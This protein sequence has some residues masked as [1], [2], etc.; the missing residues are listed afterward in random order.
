[1]LRTVSL[2]D[3]LPKF[4]QESREFQELLAAENPDVQALEDETEILKDNQF[5]L[6]CNEDGIKNFERLLG[7]T[8]A[9]DESLAFRIARVLARWNDTTPYT[10]RVFLAKLDL[11][12]GEGNYI[13][14]TNFNEYELSL[15][16]YLT[17][18]G[19]VAE[20]EYLLYY[21]IPANLLVTTRNELTVEAEGLLS[22]A[23]S[24][25]KNLSWDVPPILDLDYEVYG[26]VNHAHSATVVKHHAI[27][28]TL[29]FV[30]QSSGAIKHGHSA[31][32]AKDFTIGATL[33]TEIEAKS[34][35][36]H[37]GVA[38]TILHYEI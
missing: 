3:Y 17:Q 36:G 28:S 25:A 30:Y 21:M 8:A 33:S 1:M 18:N 2:I 32:L 10:L 4:L 31:T 11:L 7:I 12:C 16:V 5:I 35:L 14:T 24:A 9:A 20:L 37:S 15:E 13:L 26:L 22:L 27:N 6:T 38:G 29:D 19:Q 34:N 23:S